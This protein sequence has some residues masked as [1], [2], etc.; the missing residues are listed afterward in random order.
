MDAKSGLD[1]RSHAPRSSN[2]AWFAECMDAFVNVLVETMGEPQPRKAEIQID[3][4]KPGFVLRRFK[5]TL[6]HNLDS[7]TLHESVDGEDKFN[8]S[9]SYFR[10]RLRG[11][12]TTGLP[13]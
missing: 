2:A 10:K 4:V 12:L 3:K 8:F 9:D 1:S 5:S 7:G 6:M 13:R 11:R